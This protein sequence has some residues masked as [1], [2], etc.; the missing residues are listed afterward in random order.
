MP[1]STRTP[2]VAILFRERLVTLTTTS[3]NTQV[4]T[5]PAELRTLD[6]RGGACSS[7]TAGASQDSAGGGDDGLALL[8]LGEGSGSDVLVSL[9]VADCST[10]L[11]S[12]AFVEHEVVTAAQIT[13]AAASIRALE[14]IPR[15]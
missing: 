4:T 5:A 12:T 1:T 2:D 14:L 7:E 3:S 8:R 9:L 15:A 11:S 10:G 6:T 13:T